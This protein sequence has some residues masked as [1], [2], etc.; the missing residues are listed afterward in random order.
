MFKTRLQ[1]GMNRSFRELPEDYQVK[2]PISGKGSTI[3]GA[4]L[5]LAIA[6]VVAA[7]TLPAVVSPKD[8]ELRSADDILS[9]LCA[10]EAAYYA[11]NGTYARFTTLRMSGFIDSRFTQD[12]WLVVGDVKYDGPSSDGGSSFAVKATILRTGQVLMI[13]QTGAVRD[14]PGRRPTPGTLLT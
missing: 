2:G 3:V 11:Q 5:A 9:T 4:V 14:Q 13:D 7:V 8:A 1:A 6:G 10:A 12:T